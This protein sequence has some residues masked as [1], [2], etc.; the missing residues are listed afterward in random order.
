MIEHNKLSYK[1]IGAIFNVYNELGPG[2][3][4]SVYEKALLYELSIAG[5]KAKSQVSI[6]IKYKN[7][8]FE[9]GFRA[10]LIVENSIIVEIKSVDALTIV[11]HNQLVSYLKMSDK[12]LGFLVNFNTVRLKE[13]IIRKV[14]NL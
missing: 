8:K 4:E 7:I 9:V 5:I 13:N 10:D 1:V 12:K 11:H 6:P 14:N 3:L 2:M